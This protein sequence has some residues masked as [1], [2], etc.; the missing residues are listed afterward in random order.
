M[1]WIQLTIA[2]VSLAREII[3]YLKER[4]KSPVNTAEKIAQFKEGLNHARKTQ[5]TSKLEEAFA[6]IIG[7]HKL[8][9]IVSDNQNS[10]EGSDR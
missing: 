10:S 3:K 7:A 4:D 6:G 9:G 8:D 1:G 2:A 5:D